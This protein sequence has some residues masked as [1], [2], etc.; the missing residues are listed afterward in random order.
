VLDDLENVVDTLSK[1]DLERTLSKDP[2]RIFFLNETTLV[3]HPGGLHSH[4]LMQLIR[5]KN[6]GESECG[7]TQESSVLQKFPD[8]M[9]CSWT[10]LEDT[11]PLRTGTFNTETKKM[12]RRISFYLV[13]LRISIN[14]EQKWK[15]NTN[16]VW[17]NILPWWKRNGPDCSRKS[18]KQKTGRKKRGKNR[19]TR[20]APS[21]SLEVSISSGITNQ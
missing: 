6:P 10:T 20:N 17:I 3:M 7:E 21:S 14:Y 2:R 1:P 15:K 18:Q 5:K 4:K 8:L 16:L 19:K 9:R 12:V 13:Y 11:V